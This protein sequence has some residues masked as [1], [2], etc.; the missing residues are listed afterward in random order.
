MER[1]PQKQ[2][3]RSERKAEARAYR[4]QRRREVRCWFTPPFRHEFVN[5]RSEDGPV[6]GKC[7]VGCGCRPA[8]AP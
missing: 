5:V 3:A 1:D 2:A 4:Q 8:E 7:C 6:V